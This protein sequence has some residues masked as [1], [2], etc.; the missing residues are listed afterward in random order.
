MVLDDGNIVEFDTPNKLMEQQGVFYELAKDAG[1]L[2]MNTDWEVNIS[3]ANIQ[4]HCD[5]KPA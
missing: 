1:I 3:T 5:N 2:K 4:P